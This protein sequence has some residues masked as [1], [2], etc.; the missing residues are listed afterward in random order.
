MSIANTIKQ[1]IGNKALYMIGAKNLIATE[2]GLTFKI[3]RN[4]KSVSYVKIELNGA[5]LYDVQYLNGNGKLKTE[6]NDI[7]FDMLHQS[8][9]KNTELYTSL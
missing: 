9:E 1:Q 2:S 8:I 5:D 6:D 3:M 7:Y 4:S